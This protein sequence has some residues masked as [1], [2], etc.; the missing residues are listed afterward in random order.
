[1]TTAA[2]NYPRILEEP[3]NDKGGVRIFFRDWPVIYVDHAVAV[4]V[5]IIAVTSAARAKN[6]GIPNLDIEFAC[7]SSERAVSAIISVTSD[8][9]KSCLDDEN[10]A[11]NQLDKTWASFAA[12]DKA[13]CIQPREYLPSYVEWLTCLELTRDVKEMRKGR[14]APTSSDIHEC[15]VVRFLEDGT[16][17]S[18][19]TV[20]RR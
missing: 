13:R 5:V 19:D 12:S 15:P 9:Y 8:I 18:V 3:V 2:H 16:I 14:P 20:C 4:S 10:E 6:G 17:T 11:R 7:H 1:M